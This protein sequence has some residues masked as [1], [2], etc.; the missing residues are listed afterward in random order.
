[1]TSIGVSRALGVLLL[2]VIVAAPWSWWLISDDQAPTRDRR[3]TLSAAYSLATHGVLDYGFPQHGPEPAQGVSGNRREPLYPLLWAAIIAW[4]PAGEVRAHGWQ[5]F[6]QPHRCPTVA[7]L[8]KAVNWVFQSALV[9]AVG[10]GVW[11]LTGRRWYAVSWMLVVAGS[12]L[13]LSGVDS[14]ETETG[15]NLFLLLHA[16]FL[17]AAF[18]SQ[19]PKLAAVLS[20]I[21]LG[22]L[23]LV[24]A[25]FY[26]LLILYLLVAAVLLLRPLVLRGSGA[27]WPGARLFFVALCAALVIGPW[28]VRNLVVLGDW[29]VSGRGG[30]VLAIRSEYTTMAWGDFPA[31]FT[32]FT[33]DRGTWLLHE[34]YDPETVAR[35]DRRSLD[36][37]Y[38]R[39][40]KQRGAADRLAREQGISLTRAALLVIAGNLDKQVALTPLFVYRGSAP[41][42]YLSVDAY[43]HL[44]KPLRRLNEFFQRWWIP[45]LLLASGWFALW[46]PRRYLI[47]VAPAL[48][49]IAF[50][51]FLTH[52]IQRYATPLY[53][54]SVLVAAVFLF[55]LAGLIRR[56]PQPE[57]SPASG[58]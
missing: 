14:W 30:R 9:L 40:Q 54:I 35:L 48:F 25:V 2:W 17:Y 23:I 58:H 39:S 3:Q 27:L 38:R 53:G 55:Q 28:M 12:A 43:K 36:S 56:P 11:R 20:G 37:F 32:F 18:S 31:A 5:C 21:A 10:A 49:S 33:P 45:A 44:P 15:A 19:R 42:R 51:A 1:M 57:D 16:L 8:T 50:H 34:R 47:L 7:R 6:Q 46:G 22:L 52:Y 26:Y 13:L 4:D 29:S 41:P 24:K